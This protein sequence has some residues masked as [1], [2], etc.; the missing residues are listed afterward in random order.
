MKNDKH[1]S[2]KILVG[3]ALGLGAVALLITRGET[4]RRH[5][6]AGKAVIGN[7]RGSYGA[8]PIVRVPVID[9]DGNATNLQA[10]WSLPGT[11]PPNYFY[12]SKG[13]DMWLFEDPSGRIY[14]DPGTVA[15][16]SPIAGRRFRPYYPTTHPIFTG[17]R[18]TSR[19]ST[20]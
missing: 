16:G 10:V 18:P 17:D 15:P 13:D 6:A 19:K 7:D 2:G 5:E 11:V 3:G 20:T 12:E 9:P 8:R 1:L 14:V 4:S